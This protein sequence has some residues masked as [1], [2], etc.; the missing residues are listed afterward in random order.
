MYNMSNQKNDNDNLNNDN[1][2]DNK[3]SSENSLSAAQDKIK[4][5]WSP[6]NENILVEWCDYAQCYKWLNSRAHA[7]YSYWHAWFTIPAIIFSTISGTASFAQGS[8]PPNYQEFSPMVIGSINIIVGI[9]TTIQQYLK[10]SELN[11]AHRVS[12]LAWD[13]FA[14]NIKIELSKHPNERV[15]ARIFIKVCRQEFDRLME[16][17]PDIRESVIQEFNKS[18]V[19][20]EGS[21]RQKRFELLRK[22]DI[23]DRIVSVNETRHKWY[24]QL[25]GHVEDQFDD[26]AD[27]QEKL[28]KEQQDLLQEKNNELQLFAEKEKNK[29]EKQIELM[30]STKQET[31]KFGNFKRQQLILVDTYINSFIDLYERKPLKEEISSN[32]ESTVETSILNDFL[33]NYDEDNYV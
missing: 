26:L 15:E 30:K 19:G 16:T 14:R 5:E 23:C 28:I 18:F 13:K 2:N 12:A 25:E 7:K 10:I 29:L 33:E 6:E 1:D 11:E 17:S 32:M 9:L 3:D 24:K 4:L 31:E 21:K 22:P 20:K 27:N 8:L